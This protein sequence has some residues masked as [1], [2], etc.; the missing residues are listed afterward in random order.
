M[1]GFLL[2]QLLHERSDEGQE[3]RT[4]LVALASFFLAFVVAVSS[5]AYAIA[6]AMAS[7]GLD[8]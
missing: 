7:L 3:E 8:K 5:I 2:E 6:H 4:K 1:F